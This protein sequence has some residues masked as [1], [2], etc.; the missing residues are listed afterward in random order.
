MVW[1]FASSCSR[2]GLDTERDRREKTIIDGE[3]R[4]V[5]PNRRF[6][7]DTM[8]EREPVTTRVGQSET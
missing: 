8:E 3:R 4:P 7:V 6:S 5:G 2:G 1:G